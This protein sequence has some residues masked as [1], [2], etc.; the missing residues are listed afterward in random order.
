MA[1][2]W[3][4]NLASAT[5]STGFR[6]DQWIW[7]LVRP[8]LLGGSRVQP[9]SVWHAFA[10]GREWP[11][12]RWGLEAVRT[13]SH[14][15]H[16]QVLVH[17]TGLGFELEV[18][19][20]HLKSKINREPITRDAGG[21]LSGAYLAEALRARVE[22]ATEARNVREYVGAKFDQLPDPAIVIVGDCNDGPGHDLFEKDYLFFDLIGNIQGE[23]LVAERYFNHALFDAPAHLRWTARYD[24][25][26]L[27]IPA[28]RNPLLL[29]HILMSQPLCRDALPLVARAFAGR[30]EHEAFERAN[31]GSNSKTRSSDHRPVSITLT[32]R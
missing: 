13:H 7:F 5:R 15:R 14:Y 25:D 8:A 24:D 19:G 23:V 29:D 28:S 17:D 10:G 3:G 31:A 1:P 11:V 30:V 18:I 27:R 6:G 21:N 26:V 20:V 32:E 9:P 2:R 22:L 4:S 12:H 16:P